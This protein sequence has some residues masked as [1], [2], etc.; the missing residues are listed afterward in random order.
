MGIGFLMDRKKQFVNTLCVGDL[1]DDVFVLAEKSIGRK[2]NGD[3]FLN[4]SF[5]DR[6]G[7]IRGVAWDNV[8]EINGAA[9]SGAFVRVTGAVSEYRGGLQVTVRGV[10][11]CEVETVDPS[12]FLPVTARNPDRM[13]ERLK[14]TVAECV[15]DP[16]IKRLLEAFWAD[17]EFVRRFK[18]APAA[19]KMHHAYIGGLLEHTLSMT[20]LAKEIARHYSGVNLDLL[21]AGVVLHDIGKTREF[22]YQFAIGYSDEGKLLTHIVIGCA[23]IDDKI[24]ELP[25]FPSETALLVKHMVVSHHGSREYGSPEPP[26]LMEAVLLNQIDDIDAKMNGIREF[27]AGEDPNEP[28]TSYN[29]ML[30]RELYRGKP[31]EEPSE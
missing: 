10:V 21:L 14:R 28:W 30:G 16:H 1:I 31:P 15:R 4:F 2:K 20:V 13:F 27:I 23:M 9:V 29:R 17:E 12:D 7:D 22:E 26:K 6:T 25:G 11:R 3:S 18:T 8:E 19:K 5:A 24:R